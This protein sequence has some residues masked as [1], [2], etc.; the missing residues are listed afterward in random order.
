MNEYEPHKDNGKVVVLFTVAESFAY[1]VVHV[2]SRFIGYLSGPTIHSPLYW[3]ARKFLLFRLV[4]D[5]RTHVSFQMN[6]S[7]PI[8]SRTM[9]TCGHNI[10]Y[11]IC[12]TI[13]F[14]LLS[15]TPFSLFFNNLVA[16]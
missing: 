15:L 4:S 6:Q 2:L 13:G 1:S 8:H 14:E 5:V 9:Y 10:I 3:L 16:L 11:R 7:R 12:K